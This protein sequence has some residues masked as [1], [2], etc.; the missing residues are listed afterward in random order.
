MELKG[1]G[2][3]IELISVFEEAQGGL[4]EEGQNGI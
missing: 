1:I 3:G 2:M 4:K